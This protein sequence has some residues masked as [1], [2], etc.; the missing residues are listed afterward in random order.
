MTC[1]AGWFKNFRASLPIRESDQALRRRHRRDLPR[2]AAGS[3]C[4]FRLLSCSE[5]IEYP[6]ID[7]EPATPGRLDAYL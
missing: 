6:V 1:S 5:D 7:R 3:T 4:H 2:S